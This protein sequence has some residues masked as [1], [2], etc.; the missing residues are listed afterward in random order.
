MWCSAIPRLAPRARSQSSVHSAS[1]GDK[2]VLYHVLSSKTRCG[3]DWTL[4]FCV[5]PLTQAVIFFKISSA[6]F[7]PRASSDELLRNPAPNTASIMKNGSFHRKPSPC[8]DFEKSSG[9]RRPNG[10]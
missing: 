4:F 3:C 5:A 2:E 7:D 10:Q 1:N 8:F 6:S 9:T